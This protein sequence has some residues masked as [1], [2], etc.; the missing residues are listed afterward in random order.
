MLKISNILIK[1]LKFIAAMLIALSIS[2][3]LGYV[4]IIHP[5]LVKFHSLAL[6][7]IKLVFYVVFA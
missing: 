4:K 6:K 2:S 5:G 3:E 7:S 1:I